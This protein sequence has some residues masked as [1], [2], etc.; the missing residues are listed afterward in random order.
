MRHPEGDLGRRADAE[1]EDEQRQDGDLRGAV[2]QKMIGMKLRWENRLSP[3]I[4]P[5]ESPIAIDSAKA[6]NSSKNVIR[7]ALGTPGVMSTVC[8]EVK[9]LDGGLRNILST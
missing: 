2:E 1:I 6:M 5:T 8:S 9:T 3:T 7:S 4:R